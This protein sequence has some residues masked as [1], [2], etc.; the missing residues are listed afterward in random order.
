[1][2]D[3]RYVIPG[4]SYACKFKVETMLDE[5]GQ[6]VHL[7]V[8]QTANGPGM[9]EGFGLIVKRDMNTEMVELTDRKSG[10]NFFVPFDQLSDIDTVHWVETEDD[11]R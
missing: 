1:M 7:N 2:I 8:G 11:G 4:E 5:D 3:I 9:Y 6:P 10:K